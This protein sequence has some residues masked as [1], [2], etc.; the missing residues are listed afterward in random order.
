[1]KQGEKIT[2][3]WDEHEPPK[4]YIWCHDGQAY[5]Y[6]GQEWVESEYPVADLQW[7]HSNKREMVFDSNTIPPDNMVWNKDGDLLVCNDGESWGDILG[8]KVSSWL[9]VDHTNFAEARHNQLEDYYNNYPTEA[10]QDGETWPAFNPAAF[11]WFVINYDFDG[12]SKINIYRNNELIFEWKPSAMI[13]QE[14][15]NKVNR[16]Y[17][18][19][20]VPSS[21][22][23]NLPEYTETA[24]GNE[25]LVDPS[26]F[27][28]YITKE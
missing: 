6:N 4:N 10:R 11:P 23:L 12:S 14:S 18:I 8:E 15:G 19:L 24:Q 16:T 26:E 7:G 13:T 3:I 9:I 25:L 27:K 22:D 17:A 1:M 5:Q 2:I 21:E 28:V 20:S